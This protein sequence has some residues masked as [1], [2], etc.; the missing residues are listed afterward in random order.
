MRPLSTRATG[1]ARVRDRALA[2]ARAAADAGDVAAHALA[3]DR[4]DAAEEALAGLLLPDG[5]GPSVA[6]RG[7]LNV[8]AI[9]GA[10][11]AGVREC[12]RGDALPAVGS[13]W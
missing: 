3:A 2:D 10:G 5:A 6:A 9:R 1:L 7:L 13:F 11:R 8:A 4:A 12:G